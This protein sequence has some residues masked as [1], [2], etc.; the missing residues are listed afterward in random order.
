MNVAGFVRWVLFVVATIVFPAISTRADEAGR[1]FG[2]DEELPTAVENV[3]TNSGALPVL[4]AV[5][6]VRRLKRGEAEHGYPVKIQGVVTCVVQYQNGFVVQDATRAIY[7]VNSGK[8]NG[9]PQVGNFLEVEGK[10]DRGSFAPVVR[11][12]HFDFLGPGKFPEPIRPAW[13]Q[14]MN[15]ALDLLAIS[16]VVIGDQYSQ[17]GAAHLFLRS[18][19]SVMAFRRCASRYP[20]G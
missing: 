15:G 17:D 11:A 4:T 6:D 16:F 10:T 7:V 18:A 20:P 13:D 9:L 1:E 2:P 19:S 12:R 8:T 5:D 3:K 14:L